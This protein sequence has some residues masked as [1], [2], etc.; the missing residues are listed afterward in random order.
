MRSTTETS[1]VGTLEAMLQLTTVYS[2]LKAMVQLQTTVYSYLKAMPVSFPF[3]SGITCRWKRMTNETR[4]DN[5][6]EQWR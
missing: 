2:Y 5:R 3:S 1:G 4:L 6:L